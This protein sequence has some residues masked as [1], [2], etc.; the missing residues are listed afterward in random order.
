MASIWD[1]I[2]IGHMDLPQRI[3][4]SPM[5][6]SR[7]LKDGTPSPLAVEYYAQRASFGMLITE[8]T[9]PSPNGQGYLNTPGIHTPAHVDGWRKV[10]DAVHGRGGHVVI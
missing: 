9:Q 7:A 4:M 8:G 5:T 1:P 2:R 6:R 10:I 3:T